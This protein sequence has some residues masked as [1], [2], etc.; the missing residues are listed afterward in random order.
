LGGG[1]FRRGPEASK[2]ALAGLCGKAWGWGFHFVDAQVPT[3]HLERLGA[4]MVSG[5]EFR[6]RLERAM[7]DA[8]RVGRWDRG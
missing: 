1:R 8:T 5:E 4:R 3:E 2:A 6:A 7:E